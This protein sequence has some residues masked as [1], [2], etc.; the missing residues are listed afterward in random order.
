MKT[1]NQLHGSKLLRPALAAGG[2]TLVAVAATFAH[3]PAKTAT[4]VEHTASATAAIASRTWTNA[5]TGETVEG[6]FVSSADSAV[7][8]ETA[9]GTVATIP[10]A[11]LSNADQAY[12]VR[13]IAAI[14]ALNSSAALDGKES[15]A[16]GNA[17]DSSTGV[18][19]MLSMLSCMA[20]AGNGVLMASTFQPFK[21]NVRFYWDSAYFYEESDSMPDP[22]QMP[23]IMVGITSWQQQLPIPAAYFAS[24]NNP[25]NNAAGLGY[26][27]PNIWRIPLVPVPAASP[28]SLSGGNF[29]RGAIALA[30][31]G[32]PIF[33]PRNNTGAFSQA[34]GELDIY[35]G[36]CG[37]ADDYH[38]HIAPVHLQSILGVSK[39]VAW[40]LDGYPIYGYTEPDG[41]ARLALDSD[42]GHT[43]GTWGYHYHA[44][45][46]DATGPQ[47]PYLMNAFHGTVVNYG[48]QVDPQ[49]A[50]TSVE[51]DGLP[52]AGARIV[53]SSRPTANSFSMTYTY[54]NVSYVFGWTLNRATG[55]ITILRQG[56]SGSTNISYANLPRFQRYAASSK[57]MNA[58]PDTGQTASATS[59]FGEDADYLI[60]APSFTDNGN[61]T[62]TDNVTGLMWQKVDSGEMTW[63]SAVA[64]ASTLA[65]GGYTDWRL[66]TP[67][68]A[69]SILNHGRNPALDSTYFQS[70]ASGT[71]QY[72]WTGTIY[73]TDTTRVWSTNSGGGIGAHSKTQTV[74]AGGTSRFCA[75]YVRGA[76]PTLAHNYFNNGDGTITDTDTGLMWAQ[77]PGSSMNWNAALAYAEGLA[78]AGYTDWRLPNVKEL[79]SIV[80]I[81]LCSATTSASAKAA[82]NRKL[83]TTATAT[84]YW[85]STPLTGGSLTSAWLVEFGINSAVPSANGPS[86]GFQGLVSYELQT[87]TYPVLAVRTAGAGAC[88][89]PYDLNGDRVVNGSDLGTVLSGWATSNAIADVNHDGLVDGQDL[90]LVLGGWGSC[91]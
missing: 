37:R 39:P 36:H 82:L 49:P 68:E 23:N 60:N 70:N 19:S 69:F 42:G 29:Q 4:G 51:P 15:L 45:G 91:P 87:S 13:R 5:T 86:R 27:Q 83:F 41:S 73:G 65:L 79:Q 26:G 52:L 54:N 9:D 28:I 76:T 53:A 72:W 50:V 47:N 85:S 7:N 10:L 80:D 22:V 44:I 38:Y 31:N 61:G 34:I 57:S 30:A 75:R 88:D 48:G 74:S 78:T 90:A 8:I 3:P 58:L 84:A 18:P 14:A 20:P 2:A 89:C 67:A 55:V 59:T 77:V 6:A 1:T 46:S 32:I 17:P 25:E 71:S 35:G 33:N 40:A 81:T 12:A 64:G 56:P 24:L 63:E 43:H 62:V 21:P 16:D 66:P 11:D